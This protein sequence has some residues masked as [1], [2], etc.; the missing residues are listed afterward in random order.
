[1]TKE[2][3]EGA[4]LSGISEM[5]DLANRMGTDLIRFETGGVDFPTPGHIIRSA[6]AA[7]LEGK[8][9]YA[10]YKGHDN[11]RSA[12][13]GKLERK[14]GIH[15]G[16][17]EILVTTGGSEAL[18]LLFQTMLG[19]GDEVILA[20]PSWPH[21]AEM[22]RLS[23]GLP[24]EVP[25]LSEDGQ[26]FDGALLEQAI[27]SR[28][29]A[30][31]I[32][33]PHNP[34]GNV[35]S[36]SNLEQIAEIAGPKNIPVISDEVYEDL[37]YDSNKHVSMGSVYDN[38]ISLYSFSKTY[39]MCGWRMGYIAAN[40]KLVDA[41]T[42]LHI[43]S[44]TCVPS[45][46]QMA[47]QTALE[48]DQ[49]EVSKMVKAYEQRRNC[50]VNGLNSIPNIKCPVPKGALYAWPDISH[51]GSSKDVA[52]RL[53]EK[54]RCV[55]VPGSAFGSMGEGRLRLS[56]SLSEDRINEGIKR[57]KEELSSAS[58]QAAKIG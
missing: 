54:S 45:F 34:T 48:G 15:K 41:M 27:T 23:D 3:V 35:L 20:N 8:T 55:T 33:S 36:K 53:L 37:V 7:M 29:A 21:F 32:N 39:A 17:E 44:V 16:I 11:L 43:Y 10:P 40:A 31:L 5:Y 12:I 22:I 26:R 24:V 50:M 25:F 46:I 14:N 38:V 28:T 4:K 57:I 19:K 51:Y 52:K 18:F 30:I 49:S 56:L 6:N 9:N 1:M 13:A 2:L 47:G 58:A 42:K